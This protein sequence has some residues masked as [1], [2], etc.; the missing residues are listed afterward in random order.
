MKD[1]KVI[2]LEDSI[3][4]HIAISCVLKAIGI[5]AIARVGNLDEGIRRIE[6]EAIS[7][8]PFDLVITDMHFPLRSGG[9]AS[10]KAGEIVLEKLRE[11]EIEIPVIVCSSM[12][13][14]VPGAYGCVWYS[15]LRDWEKELKELV[16]RIWK[17]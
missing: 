11:R 4:K 5:S 2:H 9:E 6:T 8:T 17:M 15:E 16:E 7:G 1:I 13:M 10:W 14:K 12:N 3:L